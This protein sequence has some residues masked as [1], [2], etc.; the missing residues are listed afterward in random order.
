MWD[1]TAKE[2]IRDSQS[3]K[4]DKNPCK[5]RLTNKLQEFPTVQF[6]TLEN[7][8]QYIDYQHL[9]H[10]CSFIAISLFSQIGAIMD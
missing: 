1:C 2:I 5:N 4:N 6:F 7:S 3:L 8:M 9:I 10:H